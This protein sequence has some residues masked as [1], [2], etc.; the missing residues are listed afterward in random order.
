MDASS[1]A[2]AI[3]MNAFCNFMTIVIDPWMVM[4]VFMTV[5]FFRLVRTGML[6]I[7]AGGAI[8]GLL[9]TSAEHFPM[10]W[11]PLLG[12]ERRVNAVR[13]AVSSMTKYSLLV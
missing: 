6:E 8:P 1:A 13:W 7:L 10:T 9:F 2:L 3:W 4:F 11:R 12:V 5:G